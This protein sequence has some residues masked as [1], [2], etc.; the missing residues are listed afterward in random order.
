MTSLKRINY[1]QLPTPGGPY[2]H[3]VR[4]GSL[5]YV[6][7]LTAF[8]TEAQGQTAQQQAQAI[9]EQLAT[10]AAAEGTNLKSLIKI[11]VFLT[12]IADL[13][14]IRP[15]L[16]DYFDGALPACSLMAVSALFSPQVNVEIEAVMAV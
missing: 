5:L 13:P 9:L 12:D 8:A 11:G 14:A 6:S 7:G 2:V 1:P 3:A 16:F 4:H 15:V 10:I